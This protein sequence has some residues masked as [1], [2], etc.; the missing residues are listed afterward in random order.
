VLP[1]NLVVYRETG[2]LRRLS[3]KP[4]PPAWLLAAQTVVNLVMGVAGLVILTVVGIAA[5]GLG[6]PKDW[7]GFL[8]ANLLTITS[9]FA[10]GLCIAAVAKNSGVASAINGLLFYA[11][12]F[13]G[14]LWIPRPMMPAVLIK[15]SDIMPHGASVAASQD[16]MQGRF[17]SLKEILVLCAYTVIL[18]CLAVRYFKWE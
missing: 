17:P 18:G 5:F 15:I 2:I 3:V 6:T 10:V 8:L 12:M 16:A 7:P 14:G 13:F 9:L 4:V 1:R 11:L